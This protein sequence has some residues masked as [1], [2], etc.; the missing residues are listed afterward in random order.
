MACMLLPRPEIRITMLLMAR[1]V[2]VAM[3]FL[4]KNSGKF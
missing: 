1:I 2:P 4:I 3:L